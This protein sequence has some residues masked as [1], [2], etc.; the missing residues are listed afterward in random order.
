MIVSTLIYIRRDGRTLM[1]LRDKKNKELHGY[2]YNGV[3]G[4]LE[5]GE[6]P[7]ACAVREIREETGLVAN[8]LN[9][10]GYLCF[11]FF[12]GEVDWL[13]F[14]YECFDF[15]GDVIESDEGSLHWVMDEDIPYINVYEGDRAFLEV[16]YGSRDNFYGNF[17]YKDGKFVSCELNRLKLGEEN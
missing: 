11:P 6:T 16:L 5:R 13:C 10:R 7:E 9:Y 2:R 12:D 17:Y 15:S 14:V 1:L 3:G 8:S 4:K